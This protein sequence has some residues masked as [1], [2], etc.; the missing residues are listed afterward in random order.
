MS[1]S[2]G[3]ILNVARSAIFANQ[4]GVRIT[5]QNIA[6]AQT[7]GYTRRAI[8]FAEARPDVTP[9]GRLGTGVTV[10][11]IRRVRDGLLDDTFRREYGKAAGFE[12]RQDVLG[13]VEQIF[14][15]P[16]EEGLGA[17]LDAFWAAWSEL[18]ARP[19]NPAAQRMV[20]QTGS[21]VASTLRTFDRRLDEVQQHAVARLTESVGEV[22]GMAEQIGQLNREIVVAEGSG[23][24]AHDLRDQRDRLLDR[25]SGLGPVRVLDRGHGSIAVMLENVTLVEGPEFR[26]LAASGAP[27]AVSL[28]MDGSPVQFGGEDSFLGG[29]VRTLNTD[30]PGVRG[31]MDELAGALVEQVNSLHTAGFDR[32]GN[33][34]G[35]FFDATGVTAATIAL[36]G[37]VL[38]D[39]TKVVTSDVAGE[40]TNNRVALAMAALQGRGADNAIAASIVPGWSEMSPALSGRSMGEYYEDVVTG[41]A[42]DVRSAEHSNEVFRTIADQAEARRQ[43]V[44]GVS[45]DEELIKLMNFQQAYTAATKLVT[46]VDEMMHSVLNMV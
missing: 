9:Q 17:S 23:H 43:S 36:D 33:R 35:A 41:I 42:L 13:R 24:E 25:L 5:S 30:L 32:A 45:T 28:A 37:A 10:Q 38:A 16:S 27:P 44:S 19:T 40:T 26:K 1:S 12:L 15:E 29:L 22:N 39:P 46:T 7:E 20:Q 3:S 31:R 6:N 4:T 18:A 8:S 2:L 34:G 21:Q 11:E 14:G